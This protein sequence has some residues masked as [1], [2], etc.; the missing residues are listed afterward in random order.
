MNRRISSALL[1]LL[2]AVGL[3]LVFGDKP[4]DKPRIEP[5]TD[6]ILKKACACLTDLKLF[7]VKVEETFDEMN[8]SGQK[9]QLSNRREVLV[10]RPNCLFARSEGDTTNR[11]FYYDGKAI[12]LFDPVAKVYALHEAPATLD[13]MF[14]FLHEKLGFSIPT[15]DL[16]FSDP[17]KVLTE[18]V[19]EGEYV[20]LHHVGEKKCHHLAF[21]QRQIDW[22]LWVDAGEKPLPLKFLL[23]YRRMPGEPQFTT[24]FDW[25]VSAKVA[26]DAFQFKPP[27]DA[28]KIEFLTQKNAPPPK[29]KPEKP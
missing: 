1:L 7:A 24:V 10:R 27:A 29:K 11:L 26:E 3:P 2:F 28:K 5:K 8:A 4:A 13:A 23:T 21:Q 12:T 15:A 20:G 22:Q 18:Q 9:I 25:D 14:D 19:E 17:Y 16:L 6:D